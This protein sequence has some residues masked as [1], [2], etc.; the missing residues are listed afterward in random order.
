MG[1]AMEALL[2]ITKRCL[3]AVVKYQLLHED[4]LD[5][6]LIET[7][8][9]VNSR[10]LISVSDDI[11]DLEPLT[12]NHFLIGRLSPNTNFTNITEKNVNSRTKWKSVQA[13]TNMYWKGWIKEY[14]LLLTLQNKWTKHHENMKIRDMVTFEEDNI[15]QSKWNLA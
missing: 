14:L 6:L 15:E 9:I 13:A 3:K 8:S 1:G 11:N 7:E 4:A 12:P 5:T 2:K 10:P